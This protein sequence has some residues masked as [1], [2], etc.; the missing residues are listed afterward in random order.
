MM[1]L[2]LEIAILFGMF[3]HSKLIKALV[4]LLELYNEKVEIKL[5]NYK[6]LTYP[7]AYLRYGLEEYLTISIVALIKL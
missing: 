2:L 3:F 7:S 1:N 4:A 5:R 6:F